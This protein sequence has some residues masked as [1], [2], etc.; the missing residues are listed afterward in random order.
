MNYCSAVG[1]VGVE[2]GGESDELEVDDSV[3]RGLKVAVATGDE[4]AVVA[5]A[6]IV[7]VDVGAVSAVVV[8]VEVVV[9]GSCVGI[10]MN[11]VL[12][13]GSPSMRYT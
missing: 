12:R 2:D 9:V 1:A 13:C 8:D 4:A 7:A 5:V 11:D 10:V 6:V 3:G